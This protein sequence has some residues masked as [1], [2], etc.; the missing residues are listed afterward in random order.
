MHQDVRSPFERRCYGAKVFTLLRSLKNIERL[1]LA[2]E[3]YDVVIVPYTT[4]FFHP[5]NPFEA[6]VTVRLITKLLKR[7]HV[8]LYVYDSPVLRK[9]V[10]D[11]R[12]PLH[13]VEA[14]KQLFGAAEAIMVF[15]T[16][17]K[18]FIRDVYGIEADRLIEFHLLDNYVKF[19][20]PL[21]K[22]LG[23]PRK[24]VWA[25]NL[26]NLGSLPESVAHLR[27]AVLLAYG[28]G[29]VSSPLRRS[30]KYGGLILNEEEL[31][32]NISHADF[33]LLYYGTRASS[34]LIFGS[35]MK[36]STY[37]VSGLP[38]ITTSDAVYPA[39]LVRRYNVGWVISNV[40]QLGDLLEEI[41]E[42]EYNRVRR[43]VLALSQKIRRGYFFK[44][45]LVSSIRRVSR[46]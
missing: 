32:R 11:G 33:G 5:L 16:Y 27:G 7:A 38:V 26:S 13:A 30:V 20:P 19:T 15:N 8:I 42:V 39:L 22:T 41:D 25:G 46:R 36:F 28:Y 40:E 18:E 35:S 21:H 2:A 4:S 12:A 34:Y 6:R 43:N 29:R 14:E 44:K 3:K 1:A 23:S 9:L 31:V 45:A 17:F 24:I 37:I 10:F